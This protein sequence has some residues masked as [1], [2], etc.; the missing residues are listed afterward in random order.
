MPHFSLALEK[1][2]GQFVEG[3]VGKSG[4][5]HHEQVLQHLVGM[6]F[7]HHIILG[8]HPFTIVQTCEFLLYLH[9]LHPVHVAV[10]RHIEIAFLDMQRTVGCHI[11][12]ATE[13]EVLRVGR[14]K[15]QM[16][17]EVALHIDRVLYI[18]MIKGNSRSADR[19]R[20]GILQQAH[21][22]IID[23]HIGKHVFHRGTQNLTRLYHLTNTISLLSLDDIFLALG[24][25]AIDM[26]RYRLVDTHRE[27]EFTIIGR[28]LHLVEQILSFTEKLAFK[29]FFRK[30]VQGKGY[31]LIFVI[32]IVWM[33]G[34]I[35]FLLGCDNA[36]H[37]LHSRIVLALV[38]TPFRLHHHFIEPTAVIL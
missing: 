3:I 21:I 8:K 33:V 35:G 11:Q 36:A 19:R 7:R 9:I 26:L 24:I 29:L 4:V 38:L 37:Q 18:I 13:T 12:F 23:I 5:A 32:L 30:I 15:L 2:L 20:E 28:F 25:F 14:N 27:S 34:Q 31:L 10:V 17:A 1:Y 16:I 22:V 6:Y